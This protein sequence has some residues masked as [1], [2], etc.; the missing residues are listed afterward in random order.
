MRKIIAFVLC[1]CLLPVYALAAEDA[2][3]I[4]GVWVASA[5]RV[6]GAEVSIDEALGEGA[7]PVMVF[8]EDGRVL[9]VSL[10]DD[11]DVRS[12]EAAWEPLAGLAV[13]DKSLLVLPEEDG[14]LRL[15]TE[16]REVILRRATEEEIE[17]L[18]GRVELPQTATPA[19]AADG[20]YDWLVG[21]WVVQAATEDG[22]AVDLE[23]YMGEGATGMLVFR[24]GG[25]MTAITIE[26]DGWFDANEDTWQPFGELAASDD[27][28]IYPGDNG[29]L[30]AAQEDMTMTLRRATEEEVDFLRS[31]VALPKALEVAPAE[32]LWFLGTWE[33]MYSV[34]E[35][36]TEP[37]SILTQPGD[38]ARVT[39]QEN[40]VYV[41]DFCID[42]DQGSEELRWEIR[43]GMIY[44]GTSIVALLPDGTM[45]VNESGDILFMRR[46]EENAA[47]ARRE[48]DATVSAQIAV[49]SV[50]GPALVAVD[51]PEGLGLIYSASPAGRYLL[52]KAALGKPALYDAQTG[53]ATPLTFNMERSAAGAQLTQETLEKDYLSIIRTIAWS[54]D[55]R[56]AALVS[57]GDKALGD[58]YVLDAQT[59]EVFAPATWSKDR[60]DNDFGLVAA[61]AFAPD[62][63]LYFLLETSGEGSLYFGPTLLYAC[64]MTTQATTPVKELP[65]Y[66]SSVPYLAC[67]PGGD[68]LTIVSSSEGDHTLL[69]GAQREDM[70][71]FPIPSTSNIVLHENGMAALR[72]NEVNTVTSTISFLDLNQPAPAQFTGLVV[73]G[74]GSISQLPLLGKDYKEVPGGQ[75]IYQRWRDIRLSVKDGKYLMPL[76]VAFS[77]DG[78]Q[79]L[80][81]CTNFNLFLMNLATL[82]TTPV[83]V[84]E[85]YPNLPV[86]LRWNEDNVITVTDN[87]GIQRFRL[88]GVK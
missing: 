62:G 73:S 24:E 17:P 11:G 81:A 74:S 52:C 54:A 21:V 43:D 51:V 3:W 55:E 88:E 15:A 30:Q 85:G 63:T 75:M 28:V 1:L 61:A 87:S 47:P 58:L 5:L 39:F 71:R 8:H 64:D 41:S 78:K 26:D 82:R 66:V 16:G 56:Y 13:I 76:A 86:A 33:Y 27:V 60:A 6:E 7:F 18:R 83:T 59:G 40:N 80:L 36:E 35:E 9:S 49:S 84:G 20:A 44:A 72:V 32:S 46:L 29:A 4:V 68:V 37:S 53:T 25:S 22:Q 14:T 10:F 57:S 77:P 65:G 2:D 50:S 45:K 70:Q 67:T 19:P 12:T 79:V 31:R 34:M 48:L 23:E 38:Y 69:V 42:G